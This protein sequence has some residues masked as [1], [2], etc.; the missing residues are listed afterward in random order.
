MMLVKFAITVVVAAAT[1][2]AATTP[3]CDSFETNPFTTPCE[4]AE[5]IYTQ[6]DCSEAF[7]CLNAESNNGCYTQCQDNEF[8]QGGSEFQS[9]YCVVTMWHYHL[10]IST[11][12]QSKSKCQD[13]ILN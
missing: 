3:Q 5:Q 11:Q 10:S 13:S 12:C 4:C 8:V 2:V 1:G 7:W 6:N 9:R